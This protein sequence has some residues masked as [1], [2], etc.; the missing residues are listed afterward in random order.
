ML[1]AAGIEFG[2]KLLSLVLELTRDSRYLT[3]MP[4]FLGLPL[5]GCF[6]S[7][8]LELWNMEEVIIEAI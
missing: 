3:H 5:F 2:T 4:C 1:Y 6:G 7:I 8:L